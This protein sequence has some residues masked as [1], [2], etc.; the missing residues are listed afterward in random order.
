MLK[1]IFLVLFTYI[2]K[3]RPNG[4]SAMEPVFKMVAQSFDPSKSNLTIP[5]TAML[6]GYIFPL[7]DQCIVSSQLAVDRI[8]ERNVLKNYNLIVD[9]FD[10]KCNAAVA[11][12]L[13]IEVIE[14]AKSTYSDMP[15]LLI[16]SGCIG[17]LTVGHFMKHFNFVSVHEHVPN[18]AIV[19]ERSMFS[20]AF[21]L[22]ESLSSITVEFRI[23]FM[24]MDGTGFSCCLIL[25]PFG[26]Q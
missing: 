19:N 24:Q 26:S 12:K 4:N 25:Y 9:M 20:N 14:Q 5:F 22:S 16:G 8:A 6:G 18:I 15:P 17:G 13:S 2:E 1:I 11:V 3:A 7:G 21:L 23:S 10:E